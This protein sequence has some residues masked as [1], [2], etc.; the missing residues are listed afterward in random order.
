[1]TGTVYA[2]YSILHFYVCAHPPLNNN[3]EI[4]TY[5]QLD[6]SWFIETL[7]HLSFIN[8]LLIFL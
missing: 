5:N 7:F 6:K 1:M 3:Y 8:Q 2:F 4:D